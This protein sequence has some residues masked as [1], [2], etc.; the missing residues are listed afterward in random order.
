MWRRG[1]MFKHAIVWIDHHQ[2]RIFEFFEDR[3]QSETVKSHPHGVARRSDPSR[4]GE[5]DAQFY[6]E[7]VEALGGAGEILIVGPATA[8]L[9]LVRYAHKHAATFESRIVGLE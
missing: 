8:K 5:A 9:E 6:R 4:H 2:A 7:V 1:N 3:V